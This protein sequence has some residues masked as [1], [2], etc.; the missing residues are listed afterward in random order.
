M[1]R[2]KTPEGKWIT[3]Y[4][5]SKLHI[6]RTNRIGYSIHYFTVE[7]IEGDWPDDASL[8]AL[9]DGT[10]PEHPCNFGGQVRKF[11]NKASVDVFVD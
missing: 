7:L 8:I 1:K 5:G 2:Y 10:H 4:K 3:E 11:G 6:E 9:C